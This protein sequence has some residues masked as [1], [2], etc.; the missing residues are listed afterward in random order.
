MKCFVDASGGRGDAYAIA[1][2]HKQGKSLVID[3]VRAKQPLTIPVLALGGAG[4]LGPIVEQG[5]SALAGNVQ[6]EIIP[7][8][9]HWVTEEQPEYII[10][11]LRKFFSS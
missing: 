4:F 3:L 1:I 6:G 9:G 2:G 11:A 5:M 10:A 8:C 7:E